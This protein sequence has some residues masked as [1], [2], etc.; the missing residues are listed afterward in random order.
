MYTLLS[1]PMVYTL[2]PG[3]PR[4]KVYT[5]VFFCS[6]TSRSGD[7]PR[8]EGCHRGGAYSFFLGKQGNENQT[9]NFS[10]RSFLR[11][12]WGHGRPRL[13]VMDVRTEMLVFEGLTEVL[14]AG[15][16]SGIKMT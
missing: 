14:P 1:R 2:V 10:D 8:K 16:Y 5:I 15:P 4:K 9:R 7:R 13:R 3:F 11:L 12:P 6:V